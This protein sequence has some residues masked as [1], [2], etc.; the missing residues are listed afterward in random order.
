MHVDFVLLAEDTAF[1]VA[2]DKGG[3]SR[4]PEFGGN[5]LAHLQEAGVAGGMV[6]MA[7]FENG[8]AE[9]VICRDVDT[10]LVGKDASLNLPIGQP[11]MEGERNVLMHGLEGLEDKGV[12]CR[13]GFNS[14]GEG[15]V[16]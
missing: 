11:G 4:P 2:A 16:D 8:A 15:G 7:S 13:S 5:Q 6:I 3:E 1:Y 12:T 9:G 14:M 10:A